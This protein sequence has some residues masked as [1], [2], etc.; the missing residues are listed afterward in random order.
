MASVMIE[1]RSSAPEIIVSTGAK[2]QAEAEVDVVEEKTEARA[3]P[4]TSTAETGVQGEADGEA[5]DAEEVIKAGMEC[6]LKHLYQKED[7]KGRTSWTDV[8]PDDLNEAAENEMTA[9]FAI[10]VRNKK[11]FD[12]RKKLEIDSIVI[13]SP[14]LKNILSKVLKDYPGRFSAL[15]RT[16]STPG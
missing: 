13:Q 1:S 10:L 8:Y 11:S 6:D 14:L 7:N 2:A 3:A 16:P 15:T 9:R 4:T 5:R 12:S